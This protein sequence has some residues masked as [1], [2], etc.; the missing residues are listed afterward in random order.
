MYLRELGLSGMDSTN[1]LLDRDQWQAVVY[2]LTDRRV[3]SN[4]EEIFLY[5]SN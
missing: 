2:M 4:I 5:L 3:S 1:V